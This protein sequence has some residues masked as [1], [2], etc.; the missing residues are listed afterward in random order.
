MAATAAC[1]SRLIAADV[2]ALTSCQAAPRLALQPSPQGCA[3]HLW[4]ARSLPSTATRNGGPRSV[5]ASALEQACSHD[6]DL[7]L[8]NHINRVWVVHITQIRGGCAAG[9]WWRHGRLG[10][11]REP[12][13]PCRLCVH[14]TLGRSSNA[15]Q[16]FLVG[17]CKPENSD[18]TGN[19]S[20]ATP[21]HDIACIG[22]GQL[23]GWSYVSRDP[24]GRP[25]S[26][27]LR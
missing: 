10:L 3:L 22:R 23:D 1:R 27:L 2:S 14:S 4:H 6:L 21:A 8:H 17:R 7:G 12:A 24:P 20:E 25:P 18:S 16:H 5:S 11:H 15:G 13:E 26:P 9:V 19:F